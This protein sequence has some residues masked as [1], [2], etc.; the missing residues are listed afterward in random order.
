MYNKNFD[1]AC[2]TQKKMENECNS[3]N[4]QTESIITNAYE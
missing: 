1:N 4:Q 3:P 2:K